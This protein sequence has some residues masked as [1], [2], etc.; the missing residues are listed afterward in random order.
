MVI[1]INIL[2]VLFNTFISDITIRQK[3]L[4]LVREKERKYKQINEGDN[5]I[6]HSQKFLFLG[7]EIVRNIS[8]IKEGDNFG[9]LMF[10]LSQIRYLSNTV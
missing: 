3:F 7:E 2:Y 5:I 8:Q 1:L 6:I 10:N 9:E 4:F